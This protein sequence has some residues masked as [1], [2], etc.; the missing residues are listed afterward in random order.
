MADVWTRM[1]YKEKQW[2]TTFILATEH[3]DWEALQWLCDQAPGSNFERLSAEIN[4]ELDAYKRN[5]MPERQTRKPSYSEWDYGWT[6]P[7]HEPGPNFD[8][9]LVRF[10]KDTARAITQAAEAI[11][12]RIRK[13]HD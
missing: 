8:F 3:H 11:N 4:Y 7:P 1:N 6:P 9:D 13:R 5:S 12:V 10:S 2:Y